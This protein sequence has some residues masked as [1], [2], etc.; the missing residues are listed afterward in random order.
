MTVFKKNK[1]NNIKIVCDGYKF[2]SKMELKRYKELKL[3]QRAGKISALELQP[4]FILQKSFIVKSSKTKSGLST[5]E[6][7]KYTADF[8]YKQ[9][10]RV[11]VEEVKGHKT[12]SYQIRKRLFLARLRDLQADEFREIFKDETIIYK[13]LS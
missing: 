10:G 12:T 3:L 5:I 13:G 6:S 4:T 1:H 7:I 11:I 2:D 9:D 8:L